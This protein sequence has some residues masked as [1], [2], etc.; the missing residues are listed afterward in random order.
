MI[1]FTRYDLQC[2]ITHCHTITSAEHCL[3]CRWAR[4]CP[5]TRV[6][7][8]R[9]CVHSMSTTS[10]SFSAVSSA[11]R[12]TTSTNSC[13]WF[14]L[15]RASIPRTSRCL[16]FSVLSLSFSALTLSAGRW[17]RHPACKNLGVGLLVVLLLS[18][19]LPS[20]L[21]LLKSTM[22]TFWYHLTWVVPENG[23]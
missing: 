4:P 15:P 18:P 5:Q 11:T 12:V 14:A 16:I 10:S 2:L 3:P 13:G 21:A 9:L 22:E 23:R 20:S 8:T 17:E 6:P 7:R 1:P 19:P